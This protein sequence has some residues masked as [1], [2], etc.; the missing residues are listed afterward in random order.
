VVQR[1]VYKR[2]A[3]SGGW[4]ETVVDDV[5]VDDVVDDVVVADAL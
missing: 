1:L 2:V 5:V 3:A 4:S